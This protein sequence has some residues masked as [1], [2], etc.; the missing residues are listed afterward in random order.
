M[1]NII[2]EEIKIIYKNYMEMDVCSV[3]DYLNSIAIE[4]KCVK[5]TVK[6][7]IANYAQSLDEEKY[8][9]YLK[10]VEELKLKKFLYVKAIDELLDK[11]NKNDVIDF[12]LYGTQTELIK[13]IERYRKNNLGSEKELDYLLIKVQE[14]FIEKKKTNEMERFLEKQSINNIFMLDNNSDTARYICDI[15]EILKCKTDNEAVTYMRKI[16]LSSSCF[17]DMLAKFELRYQNSSEY[18]PILKRRFEKYK[19]FVQL[20]KCDNIH[21]QKMLDIQKE[22]YDYNVQIVNDLINSNYS[23]EEYCHH[24]LLFNIEDIEKSIAIVY[25]NKKTKIDDIKRKINNR[26]NQ[27]I[28]DL[29]NIVFRI[30]TN[31]DY[32]YFD[33]YMDTK[34]SFK[35]FL[36][37]VK[38]YDLLNLEVKCFINS[39]KN[40]INGDITKYKINKEMELRCERIIK[41]RLITIE[42]K[43][44]IFDFFEDNQIPLIFSTYKSA[45]NRYLSGTL[46]IE[47]Y[48]SLKK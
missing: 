3:E 17:N 22:Q 19:E 26:S 11:I 34:L 15:K 10:R 29:K 5:E 33:Y 28:R 42:E 21:I 24:N 14:Y 6:N 45:L 23:I 13:S 8:N 1:V 39:S 40:S 2:E 12:R 9:D 37:L 7:H 35:D 30:S 18:I 43:M 20:D 31:K 48:K 27:I 41:Q 16:Q 25:C 38:K 46:D 36:K 32:D 44:K 4:K 47:S